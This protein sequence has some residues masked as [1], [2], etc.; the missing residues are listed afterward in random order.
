MKNLYLLLF[1]LIPFI[2][3][4]QTY[5]V[6]IQK[7]NVEWIGEKPTGTHNGNILIKEGYINLDNNKQIKSGQFILDMQSINCTDLTGKKKN[8]LDEHLKNEDFFNTENHPTA[9]FIITSAS[10]EKIDGTLTIKDITHNISFTYKTIDSLTYSAEIIVDRT[11]YNVKYKSKTIFPDLV[12]NFIYDN[13]T[14]KLNSLI[15]E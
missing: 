14:I 12:D 5:N 6:D 1:F 3:V 13:F 7:S 11:K 4:A 2:F 15:L 8:Y 9:T 10:P